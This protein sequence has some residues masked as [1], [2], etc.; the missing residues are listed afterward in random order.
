MTFYHLHYT[1]LRINLMK[2]RHRISSFVVPIVRNKKLVVNAFISEKYFLPRASAIIYKLSRCPLVKYYAIIDTNVLV[3][4][5]LSSR[6][7][8]LSLA[9]STWIPFNVPSRNILLCLPRNRFCC[10]SYPDPWKLCI[11]MSARSEG[12]AY[13]PS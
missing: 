9:T 5:V 1:E 3:S 8:S 13:S 10:R 11:V 7:R 2:H 6:G 4:A 12:G